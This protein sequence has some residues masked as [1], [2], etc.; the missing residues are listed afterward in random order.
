MNSTL[1]NILRFFA[2]VLVQVL[3]INHIKIGGYVNPYVY[4]LFI[5]L[6]PIG[7]SK[8]GLL[9]LAF[10]SGLS[11][12]L[13]MGTP[14]LH[15]GATTLMAFCRPAIIKLVSGNPNNDLHKEPNFNNMGF[16]WWLRYSLVLM[17]VHALTLFLLESF[18]FTLF[19]QA[20]LRT[21]IS[22]PISIFL[23]TIILY[24]FSS[25]KKIND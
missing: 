16:D 3:F 2:L 9:F 13:F 11:V 4:P 21:L 18:T 14:G 5:L 10:L 22:L 20:L 17:T 23:I 7:Y 8:A 12:D 1:K 15:A 6:L 25:S 19:W 24:L